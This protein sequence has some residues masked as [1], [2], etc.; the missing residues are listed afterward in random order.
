MYIESAPY[1]DMLLV[2]A[3]I[4]GLAYILL[5]KSEKS[6]VRTGDCRWA[7][8]VLDQPWQS[9]THFTR[10]SR[11]YSLSLSLSTLNTHIYC[12]LVVLK[13]NMIE[14]LSFYIWVTLNIII[15]TFVN[16]NNFK[17]LIKITK[18]QKN[19]WHTLSKLDFK[20]ENAI[21]S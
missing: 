18:C 2:D 16:L 12:W 20:W 11:W 8:A 15:W 4:A 3:L 17:Y 10:R 9:R 7:L 13:S 5:E 14:F 6:W 1:I 21:M 19:S